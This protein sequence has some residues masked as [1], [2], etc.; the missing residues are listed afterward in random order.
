MELVDHPLDVHGLATDACRDQA[1]GGRHALD[2]DILLFIRDDHPPDARITRLHD[3]AEGDIAA[4]E[5]LEL[6]GD[7]LEDVRDVGAAFEPGD[8]TARISPGTGMLLEGRE[9]PEESLVEARHVRGGNGLQITE[10]NVGG[11]HRSQTPVVRAAK[12]AN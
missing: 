2:A 1:H 9:I 7:M 3:P 5:C 8:E 10:P 4:G 6:E 11:D 12:S